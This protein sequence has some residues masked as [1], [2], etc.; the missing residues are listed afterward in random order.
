M[1]DALCCS[2]SAQPERSILRGHA[3]AGVC[4]STSSCMAC[5]PKVRISTFLIRHYLLQYLLPV[6]ILYDSIPSPT[7]ALLVAH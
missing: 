6:G 4:H 5:Y 7:S 1:T 3:A 2:N